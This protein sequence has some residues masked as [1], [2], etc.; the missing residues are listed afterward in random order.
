MPVSVINSTESEPFVR[1]VHKEMEN[2]FQDE[3][4]D[5]K[6]INS[7]KCQQKTTK[8]KC[9][10]IKCGTEVENLSIKDFEDKILKQFLWKNKKL[11]RYYAIVLK[12]Y[13]FNDFFHHDF[14][15]YPIINLNMTENFPNS[16]VKNA[17]KN[18]F[19]R[20]GNPLLGRTR[21]PYPIVDHILYLS[22]GDD[23]HLNDLNFKFRLLK[24]KG[25]LNV[26]SE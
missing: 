22:M 1:T 24:E 12:D 11:S 17:V 26:K 15:S 21:F 14:L 5:S 4:I 18:L 16:C 9:G 19:L 25:T 6:I 10:L 23:E 3:K 20:R 2:L 8:K 7:H 13:I